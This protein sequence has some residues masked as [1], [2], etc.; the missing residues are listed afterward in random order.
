MPTLTVVLAILLPA[1]AAEPPVPRQDTAAP[2]AEGADALA[3]DAL[4]DESEAG[5]ELLVEGRN[6]RLGDAASNSASVTVVEVDERLAASADVGAVLDATAGTTVVHL[7]GLGDFTA[8]SIRGSSLR[9]VAVFLD[10]V[11]LNPDGSDVVNLSELPLQAFDRVL[12]WRGS[13]PPL[14]AASPVGGVVDL[15]TADDPEG[16]VALSYGQYDTARLFA[17]DGFDGQ[18]AGRRVDALVMADLFTTG[19]EFTYF[20]DNATIYTITDD[21][22]ARR[23]NNDKSQLSSIGRVRWGDSRLRLTLQDA[24]LSREEGVPGSTSTPTLDTRLA[25]LR[26]LALARVEARQGSWRSDARLWLQQ[27]QETWDDRQGESGEGSRWERSWFSTVG[28]QEHLLF[29]PESWLS[30]SAT[31]ALRRDGYVQADLV[32][33]RVEYPRVRWSGTAAL[34]ADLRLW[35]DR[36]TLSPVLQ[37]QWL[38]NRALGT[39]AYGSYTLEPDDHQADAWLTPRFGALL[40]PW[41]AL[42]FKANIARNVRPPDLTEL[43]GDR[44]SMQGN[45]TLE[46]ER[47][48]TWDVGAHVQL[49]VSGPLNGSLDLAHYWSRTEDLIVMVQNSQRTSVPVNFGLTWVQGLE[50]AL[51]LQLLDVV[52]SRSSLSWTISRNLTPDPGVAD[53][54]LPRI[55]QLEVH[56]ATGLHWQERVRLGHTWSY[57]DGNYWDATNFY[58]AAPRSLHGAFLRLAPDPAWPSLELSVL[59]LADRIVEVVPRN[60]LD[61]TDDSRIVA[62]ITD[63]VGYPLPGRTWMATLRWAGF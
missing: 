1:V 44:G 19:G 43:F 32:E 53:N 7:G 24:F 28:L 18:L 21:R 9:Q 59:N 30:T 34:A 48:L 56:Q 45:T 6:A 4:A 11:P 39:L 12:V 14:Y 10:G 54:Q 60:P 62:S 50:A 29:V 38:D 51:D 20:D 33:D 2:A 23:F 55:P 26:N 35:S 37:G 17:L 25:T 27:R 16:A 22:L 41:P 49:P 5:E 47:G 46:P 36:L 13:A 57:S 52:D 15:R 8:V 61:E 63:Y 3:E 58:R 31:V 40:R 42:A